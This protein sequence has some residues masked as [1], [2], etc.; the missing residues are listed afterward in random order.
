MDGAAARIVV[1]N[2][3]LVEN[4]VLPKYF[5]HSSFA[6]LRRQLNYFDFTRIGRGRRNDVKATYQNPSVLILPDI[7]KLKRKTNRTSSSK[8]HVSISLSEDKQ[9][10]ICKSSSR[11]N[12]KQ[13]CLEIPK[14]QKQSAM[15]KIM[16]DEELAKG[17]SVAST[18]F[19]RSVSMLPSCV[20]FSSFGEIQSEDKVQEDS[21][22]PTCR[23]KSDTPRIVL[24]LTQPS[25]SSEFIDDFCSSYTLE[26]WNR[27]VQNKKKITSYAKEDLMMCS[28]LLNLGRLK[29]LK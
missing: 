7:L 4:E 21:G 9:P 11:F 17:V 26:N 25:E 2:R 20:S 15:E 23:D 12:K 1:H 16:S 19:N 8:V 29:H 13:Y 28:V 27:I 18:S 22:V 3:F 6:S 14:R 24:D 5:N 10:M